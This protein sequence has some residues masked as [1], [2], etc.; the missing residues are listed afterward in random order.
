[1]KNNSYRYSNYFELLTKYRASIAATTFYPTIKYWESTASGCLTFI[2][3]TLFQYVN[4]KGIMM[5][6][7]TISIY[8]D[9]HKYEFIDRECRNNEY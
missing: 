1:M 5:G 2:E 4:P 9:F 6:I 7:T 3:I 8:T